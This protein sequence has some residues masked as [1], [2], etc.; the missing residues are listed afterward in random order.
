MGQDEENMAAANEEEDPMALE[1]RAEIE[2]L[3]AELTD[4]L[5]TEEE[6]S[7]KPAEQLAYTEE[8]E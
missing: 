5:H 7:E 3:E 8:E 4:L 6:N 1:L 2:T